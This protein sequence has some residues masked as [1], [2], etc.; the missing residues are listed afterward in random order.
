MSLRL[1]GFMGAPCCQY[2]A[3]PS[4]PRQDSGPGHP[5][6][7]PPA[8][9]LASPAA[10]SPNGPRGGTA[11]AR[12]VSLVGVVSACSGGRANQGAVSAWGSALMSFGGPGL[13]GA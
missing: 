10:S 9:S 6:F 1:A 3:L 13:W 5:N 11:Q 12:P 8:G 4:S 7:R 2:E